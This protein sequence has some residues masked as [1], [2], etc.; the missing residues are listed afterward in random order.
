MQGTAKSNA[1]L[2]Y[3]IR[4][5]KARKTGNSEVSNNRVGLTLLSDKS[6]DSTQAIVSLITD[7]R[8][9]FEYN[10]K[11]LQV[12]IKSVGQECPTHT[13]PVCPNGLLEKM[14][15]YRRKP[16][17]YQKAGRAVFVTF[18]KGSS[19][20]FP[21]E[22]RS[23][24]LQSCLHDHG[25]R[26]QLHVAVVM[27]EHVHLLLKPLGDEKGWPYGL[28]AILKLIKGTSARSINKLLG[29]SGPIWQEESFD[30]SGAPFSGRQRIG[31]LKKL[32]SLLRV[33]GRGLDTFGDFVAIAEEWQHFCNRWST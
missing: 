9:D 18:C 23:L 28:P 6:Q 7:D 13:G 21:L 27:T 16:P 10:V 5:R 33:L 25:K 19:E 14:Y 2:L 31:S 12:K 15:E 22:A 24:V 30:H 26:Y 20:P 8:T 1:A 4:S 17:H 3:L 29:S 32:R 11:R